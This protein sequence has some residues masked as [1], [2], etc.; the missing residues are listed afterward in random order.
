[1]TAA[2]NAIS[3]GEL[4]KGQVGRIISVEGDH[5]QRLMEMGFLE[6]TRIELL[7]EAPWSGDPIAINIRG[8]LI[9]LRRT[10][11]DAVRVCLDEV[12]HG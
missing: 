1:M 12:T 5:A 6:G 2:S 7:H 9:A 11:A 10:E 4:K 3:M 8:S